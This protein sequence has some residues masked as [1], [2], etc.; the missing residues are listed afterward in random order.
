[1]KDLEG[2]I[3]KVIDFGD[4]I[5]QFAKDFAKELVYEVAEN[6]RRNTNMPKILHNNF[7][8]S[9]FYNLIMK[10]LNIANPYKKI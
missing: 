10:W 3:L 2:E 1:M 8:D 5:N 9:A 7:F 4:D 6:I